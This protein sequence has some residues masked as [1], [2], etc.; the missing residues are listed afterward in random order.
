M[1]MKDQ[2]LAEGT[3]VGTDLITTMVVADQITMEAATVTTTALERKSAA[4]AIT[5]TTT[6]KS[7]A[8]ILNT[9]VKNL[10]SD[11]FYCH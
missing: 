9:M 2:L 4:T 5:I 7:A 1:L 6:M 3:L 10:L 11:N 8:L